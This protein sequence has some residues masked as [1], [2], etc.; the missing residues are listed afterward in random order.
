MAHEDTNGDEKLDYSEFQSA[1][2]K[3]YSVTMVTLDENLAINRIVAHEGDNVEIRCDITGEPQR[4]AIKWYR[5]GVDLTTLSVPYLKVFSDGALYLTDLQLSFAGNY[6]CQAVNNPTVK[7]THIVRVLVNPVVEVAPRFQWTPI[8][9]VASFECRFETFEDDVE[10]SWFKNDHQLLDGPRVT[11]LANGTQL[12]VAALEQTDTG[13]YTCRL[14]HPSGARG[15][16]VASLL[17]QDETVEAA[18]SESKPQRLWVFHATGV[19]IYEGPFSTFL[20]AHD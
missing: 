4:P 14:A 10:V 15:Q 16:S 19:T 8:G 3:L 13:A 12:Q 18:T 1:F 6:S 17:V 5:H 7:Q 11:I 9:G 2:N 20:L